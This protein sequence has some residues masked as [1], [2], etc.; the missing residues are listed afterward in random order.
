M[1]TLTYKIEFYS[2]WHTSSGLS[3]GT[4]ANLTV[5]KNTDGLPIIKGRTLKG[6]LKDAA[7]HIQYFDPNRVSQDFID[8]V[9]GIGEDEE[10]IMS[11]KGNS[12]V[13]LTSESY[14]FFGNAEL[15]A[16]LSK[17]ISLD[18]T[19]HLLYT[20][21]SSTAIDKNGLAN[22]KALRT[23]EVT[24]PLTLYAQ[25]EHFPVE[26]QEQ[27]EYCFQWIKRIGLNRHRGLGRCQFSLQNIT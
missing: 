8:E 17:Q 1:S 23:L 11:R 2:Y 6:L 27:I 16:Q 26:W 13:P 24:I 7:C 3:A 15:S 21:L 4:E 22:E 9:F 25:I 12:F 20:T 5:L 18:Q 10:R 14:C 19:I